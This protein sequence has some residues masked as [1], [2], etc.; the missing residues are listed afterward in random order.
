MYVVTGSG[1]ARAQSDA[2][3]I[4]I[5]VTDA[6]TKRPIPEARVIL[7]GPFLAQEVCGPD[8]KV[9]FEAAPAGIYRARV[10]KDSYAEAT[11]EEF[12]VLAGRVVTVDVALAKHQELKVIETITVTARQGIGGNEITGRS[13]YRRLSQSL[14]AALGKILGINVSGE[15]A[16]SDEPTETISLEGHDP[17]QTALTLDGIPL[18][19]PGQAADLHAIDP[20]LF[21][22]ASVDFA[23]SAGALGGS[24]NFRTLE[25]TLSWQ[26][27]A[28]TALDS[29]GGSYSTLSERGSYGGLGVAFVHSVRGHASPLDDFFYRDTSGLAYAHHGGHLAGGNLL[30][31]RTHLGREQTLTGTLL[32]SNTDDDVLCSLFTGPLPCGYGPNNREY[33]H[34]SAFSL[35]DTALIGLVGL[36]LSLFDLSSRNDQDLSHRYVAGV[37]SPFAQET[38]SRTRGATLDAQLASHGRH[39]FSVQAATSRQLQ[40][41]FALTPA[42]TAFVS[43][44]SAMNFSTLTLSDEVHANTRLRLSSHL[45]FS[46]SNTAGTALLG[47]A[48]AAWAPNGRDR[49]AASLD[50]G[51]SGAPPPPGGTLTD[52]ASLNFNCAAGLAFAQGPG[53]RPGPQS[54]TSA[55]LSYTHLLHDGG[56]QATFYRQ[57]QRDTLVDALVNAQALPASYFPAGYFSAAQQLFQSAGGCSSAAAFAPPN[58]YVQLP[59]GGSTLVYEGMQL[60]RLGAIAPR[61]LG[62]FTYAT[63]VAKAI[64]TDARLHLGRSPEV[65]GAQLPDIPLHR[66]ALAV[67]YRAPRLPMEWL[68]DAQ[69][70]SANNPANL[71]AYVTLDAGL[72]IEFHGTSLTLLATNLFDAG[73]GTFVT[74]VGAVPLET[75]SG[76]A[77]PTL[78]FP[79]APRTYSATLTMRVGGTGAPVQQGPEAL[80]APLPERAPTQPLAVDRTRSLCSSADAALAASS[81]AALRGYIAAVEAA[82]TSAG[83]PDAAPAAAPEVPGITVIY[84]KAGGSYALSLV[85]TRI[86]VVQALFRCVLLHT[87]TDEQARALGLYIPP[88]SPFARFTLTYSPKA[89]LYALELPASSGAEEF[90]LY[91]LP[92]QPPRAPFALESKRPE[93]TPELR[94]VASTLLASLQRYAGAFEPQHPPTPPEGWRVVPHVTASTW[95][96][97]VIPENFANLPAILDCGHVALADRNAVKARG[98]D[99]AAAPSLNYAPAIGLYLIRPAG[100]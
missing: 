16:Q 34:F 100:E 30:K 36:R 92:A 70:V 15:G 61:T 73:A 31:L 85:A 41:T 12:E 2:G 84:H 20:D 74:P 39:T 80:F 19:A 53:D 38:R 25:P 98:L 43:P 44:G 22:A 13:T 81:T 94:A 58:L 23:P 27:E 35:S 87:G 46:S 49:L 79:L 76:P 69:Y 72:S 40:Q 9:V 90:R 96:L 51:N 10:V 75:T 17:T 7:E 95:W 54:S 67:E 60:S 42:S 3:S 56:I 6:A 50:V 99:G 4:E 45:G 77:L 33:G 93:C 55:R 89:G 14:S 29:N 8:G 65:P 82:K 24:V 71:S 62:G 26:G 1:E 86:E 57:V 47:G 78:A 97:D 83:Y 28:T 63:T 11:T 21:S 91:R 64:S 59:I 32:A 88:S 18:S 37:P 48:S 66:A 5:V 68:M 52:P